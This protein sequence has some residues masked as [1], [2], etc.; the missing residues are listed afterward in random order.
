MWTCQCLTT[1]HAANAARIALSA[2]NG[3][4]AESVTLNG[5]GRLQVEIRAVVNSRFTISFAPAALAE[6]STAD[7]AAVDAGNA[8]PTEPLV[9]GPPAIAAIDEGDAADISVFLPLATR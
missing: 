3:T 9:A 8:D 5:P 2:N 7:A 6:A 4:A 1:L